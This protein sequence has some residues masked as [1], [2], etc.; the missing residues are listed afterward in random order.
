VNVASLTSSANTLRK[1]L[2]L[3]QSL[4]AG[5]SQMQIENTSTGHAALQLKTFS[6]TTQF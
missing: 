6:N 1:E 3:T 5:T 4:F 2:T